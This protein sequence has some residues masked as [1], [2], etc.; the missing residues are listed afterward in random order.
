MRSFSRIAT[1]LVCSLVLS[2]CESAYYSINEQF[3]RMKRDILVDRA[4]D[5]MQAQ[6]EAEE[7]FKDAFTQFEAVVGIPES[8]LKSTYNR[9][10]SA[11]EDAEAQAG[12]V[13]DRIDAVEDVAEDLFEEWQEELEQIGNANLRSQS[14]Q[15]LRATR[16]RANSLVK[17]MRKAESRMAPVLDTFRDHVLF[18]KHNL[19]ARAVASLQGELQG[20]ETNVGRLIREME[21]SIAEAQSFIKQES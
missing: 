20:I 6:E 19:N 14:A 16:T 3:G 2:A 21:V 4:E 17:A 10:N 11:F 15:Q 8:D 18:L 5:A 13:S 9:L 1:V 12:E 7:E